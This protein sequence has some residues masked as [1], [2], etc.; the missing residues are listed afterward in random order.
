MV[1]DRW[2][3]HRPALQLPPEHPSSPPP[4]PDQARAERGRRLLCWLRSPLRGYAGPA[5]R[6][7]SPSRPVPAGARSPTRAPS[8]G[9]PHAATAAPAGRDSRPVCPGPACGHGACRRSRSSLRRRSSASRRTLPQATRSV[10]SARRRT[11]GPAGP[12]RHDRPQRQPRHQAS[13]RKERG[14]GEDR[15]GRPDAADRQYRADGA[16]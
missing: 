4:P 14:D 16:D 11:D 13:G 8:A 12:P 15:P 5:R 7:A 9:A 10:F 2:R 3:R 1:S 6:R